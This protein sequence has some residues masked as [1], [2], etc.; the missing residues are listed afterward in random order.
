MD[1]Q[2]DNLQITGVRQGAVNFFGNV[3]LDLY[4]TSGANSNSNAFLSV[5]NTL[6]DIV[7]NDNIR[8]LGLDGVDTTKYQSA[9]ALQ[10]KQGLFVD[11]MQIQ[12]ASGVVPDNIN[13]ANGIFVKS[14]EPLIYAKNF[15]ANVYVAN[16]TNITSITNTTLNTNNTYVKFNAS[17]SLD[18][19]INNGYTSEWTDLNTSSFDFAGTSSAIQDR[20]EVQDTVAKSSFLHNNFLT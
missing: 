5:V 18:Y 16:S 9:D 1:E 14:Y 15:D 10:K 19:A 7:H 6:N 8:I 17:T 12:N 11:L 20:L 2:I 13:S 4:I 3:L